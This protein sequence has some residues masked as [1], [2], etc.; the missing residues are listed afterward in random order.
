VTSG[1]R[2][3]ERE[4]DGEYHRSRLLLSLKR[5]MRWSTVGGVGGMYAS[6]SCGTLIRLVLRPPSEP[7]L[8][9][10]AAYADQSIE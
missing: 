3:A 9:R 10:R 4:V 1:R 6:L 2:P 8:E 7:S 5:L